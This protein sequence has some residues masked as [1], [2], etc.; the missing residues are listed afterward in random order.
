MLLSLSSSFFPHSVYFS[1]LNQNLSGQN[2]STPMLKIQN[3]HLERQFLQPKVSNR[4]SVWTETQLQSRDSLSLSLSSKTVYKECK[5]CIEMWT[6]GVA[7]RQRVHEG[8]REGGR[9]KQR[10]KASLE[11]TKTTKG[12]HGSSFVHY[13]MGYISSQTN[14]IG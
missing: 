14:V 5:I 7:A 6:L 11:R 10:K 13:V 9:K 3:E 12:V 2:L 4:F 8:G 1:I